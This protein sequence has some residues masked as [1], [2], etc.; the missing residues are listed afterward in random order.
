MKTYT[1]IVQML[2]ALTSELPINVNVTAA[3]RDEALHQACPNFESM[4]TNTTMATVSTTID[5]QHL[6]WR[7]W[8]K[9]DW[10]GPLKEPTRK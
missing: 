3:S 1:V 9:I 5:G 7:K 10:S 2:Y 4:K 8:P 6:T